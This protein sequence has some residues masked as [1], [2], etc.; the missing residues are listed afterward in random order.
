M[1]LDNPD[2]EYKTVADKG[3]SHFG[4]YADALV[5]IKGILEK[6]GDTFVVP[7]TE[8]DALLK[9]IISHRRKRP[10]VFF[11]RELW[12]LDFSKD[13]KP[14]RK[15]NADRALKANKAKPLKVHPGELVST[16][17]LW[18]YLNQWENADTSTLSVDLE[19]FNQV[20]TGCIFIFKKRSRQFEEAKLLLGASIIFVHL[21]KSLMLP[22][23]AQSEDVSFKQSLEIVLNKSD[24]AL[25]SD[26]QRLSSGYRSKL[27]AYL[28]IPEPEYS[29][30]KALFEFYKASVSVI[31]EYLE[32][33]FS[34]EGISLQANANKT[35]NQDQGATAK[36]ARAL[37]SEPLDDYLKKF[38][39]K[40]PEEQALV[41]DSAFLAYENLS[42]FFGKL[43]PDA[44]RKKRKSLKAQIQRLQE[45]EGKLG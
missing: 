32:K 9:E 44:L 24:A 15:A 20:L 45:L 16:E 11:A 6:D 40:K 42:D 19:E 10:I 33:R 29:D 41:I 17:H 12:G 25:K 22:E 34:D 31:P 5:K 4:Y 26:I 3:D 39:K 2:G 37:L 35:S 21:Q 27:A 14:L 36:R 8:R 38:K 28:N 43:E 30:P 7:E 13:I 18:N 23:E 1:Y